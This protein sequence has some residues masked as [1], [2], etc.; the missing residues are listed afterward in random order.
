M[1][2]RLTALG[3]ARVCW[4]VISS[5]F[6]QMIKL[7]ASQYRILSIDEALNGAINN[8]NILRCN[9]ESE[10]LTQRDELT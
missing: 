10:G 2:R 1:K 4:R 5:E 7:F 6:Y 9:M 3:E 8:I